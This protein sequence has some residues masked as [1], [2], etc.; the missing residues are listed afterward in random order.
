MPYSSRS[1]KELPISPD[2]R[3][4]FLRALGRALPG[5]W[6][7]RRRVLTE[8]RH[9]LEDSI[10][11]G[12]AEGLPDDVAIGRALGRLGDVETIADSF[13]ATPVRTRSF[14]KAISVVPTAWIA[15]GAMAVASLVLVDLAPASGA[16]VSPSP[17]TVRVRPNAQPHARRSH[18]RRTWA[19]DTRSARSFQLRGR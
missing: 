16:K 5:N 13:R 6:F 11:E 19:S 7:A 3:S 4:D 8:I 2:P 1:R 10:G 18:V 14:W 12:R 17:K 9:H 15:A